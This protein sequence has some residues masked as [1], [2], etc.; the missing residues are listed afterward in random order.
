MALV[1]KW[2]DGTSYSRHSSRARGRSGASSG[3]AL[4]D[5]TTS[6]A[7]GKRSLAIFSRSS[8]PMVFL[9]ST[10]SGCAKWHMMQRSWHRPTMSSLTRRNLF[11]RTI[12]IELR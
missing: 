11:S 8:P 3:S 9:F 5:S 2:K 6:W 7:M 12:G 1:E 4:D 10:K